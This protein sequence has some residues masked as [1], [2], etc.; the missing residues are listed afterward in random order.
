V[1]QTVKLNAGDAWTYHSLI[2]R[3][4]LV[5]SFFVIGGIVAMWVVRLKRG[6]TNVAL[7][8]GQALEGGLKGFGKKMCMT[9][10]SG[11]EERRLDSIS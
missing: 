9:Y 7:G 5:F 4:M 10:W 3:G 2:F 8:S 6:E 11:W 1:C